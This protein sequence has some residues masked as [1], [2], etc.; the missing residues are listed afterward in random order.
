[1]SAAG[2]LPFYPGT[3]FQHDMYVSAVLCL[4]DTGQQTQFWHNNFNS[5]C[6][7]HYLK[8]ISIFI[9]IYREKNV[10]MFIHTYYLLMNLYKFTSMCFMCFR[11]LLRENSTSMCSETHFTVYV[12]TVSLWLP[13]LQNTKECQRSKCFYRGKEKYQG[14]SWILLIFNIP[15]KLHLVD[16]KFWAVSHRQK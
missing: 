12:R 3:F 2:F 9:A 6:K 13:Y 8:V 5:P 16:E 15:P 4:H 7:S 10:I 11:E 1:M 14:Y